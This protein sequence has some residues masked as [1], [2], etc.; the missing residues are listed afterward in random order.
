MTDLQ[1]KLNHRIAIPIKLF[2]SQ[3]NAGGIVL[4]ISI[5]VAM[6]LANSNLSHGYF[7]FFEQEFGFVMNGQRYLYYSLHHWINDGLMA[8]FF[9][10]VGLEL[11]GEF[12][13]GELSQPR[14][15][16]LPIGAAFGGMVV[17]ALLYASLNLG[18]PAI[19]GWG[20]PMA[21]DIAFALG[22]VVLLGK[23]VPASVKVFLTTLAVMDDLGAVIVIALF[24]TSHISIANL[25]IGIGFL[26]LMFILNKLGVKN[27]YVYGLLGVG[28]VWVAFLLS[29]IHATIAAVLAAFMIP[30][31]SVVNETA[32]RQRMRKHVRRFESVPPNQ[33]RTLEKEQVH[34]ITDIQK[35]STSAIPPLQLLEHYLSPF[36]TFFVIPVFAI[37]NAGINFSGLDLQQVFST[38]VMV[39]V[40]IGLLLGKPIG[41]IGATL[42]LSKL[43]AAELPKDITLRRLMGIG[44]LASIGF[45]MSVFISTLA[46]TSDAMLTQAKIGILI[47]S[48]LGGFIG[49]RLLRK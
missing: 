49:Y 18:T 10:V 23:R 1:N 34:I 33:V 15:A 6:F 27:V 4:G 3:Q 43:H 13:G 37:C 17:P 19:S 28:G 40:A 45:T 44:F 31:D 9:F 38:N 29:G 5:I 47:A 20:I 36:V 41:V 25:L 21:T 2:M 26:A 39:G 11:K 46:F 30:A 32:Y 42:L 24:Y 8:I 16:I 14:N 7:E 12:I 35:D 22:V 48:V